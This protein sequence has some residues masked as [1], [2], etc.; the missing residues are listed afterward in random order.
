MLFTVS[1]SKWDAGMAA[2]AATKGFFAQANLL[3]PLWIPA[4]RRL[5]K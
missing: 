2:C 3:K 1:A 4:P 5:S